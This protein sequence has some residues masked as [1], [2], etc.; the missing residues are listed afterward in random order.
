MQQIGSVDATAVDPDANTKT[1]QPDGEYDKSERPDLRQIGAEKL[2]AMYAASEERLRR[3]F[4]GDQ[5]DHFVGIDARYPEGYQG[6]TL[7]E[8]SSGSPEADESVPADYEFTGGVDDFKAETVTISGDQADV[9]GSATIWL[10]G[11]TVWPDSTHVV[12]PSSEVTF[13]AH[14]VLVGDDWKVD[15]YDDTFAPGSGP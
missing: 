3:Y 9:T 6:L 12:T 8:G 2:P 5:L 13:K 15:A 1:T 10:N 11:A 14:L 4:T 7:P